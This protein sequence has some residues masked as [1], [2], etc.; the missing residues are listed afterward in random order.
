[1]FFMIKINS[2]PGD[3][4]YIINQSTIPDSH[5]RC[6]DLSGD[7]LCDSTLSESFSQPFHLVRTPMAENDMWRLKSV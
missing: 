6:V 3:L 7:T 2:S 5:R 1:M 4:T